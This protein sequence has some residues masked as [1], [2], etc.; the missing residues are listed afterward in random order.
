MV[1]AFP[2]RVYLPT[3]LLLDALGLGLQAL[4]PLGL[5]ALGLGLQ[6][7]LG[8]PQQPGPGELQWPRARKSEVCRLVGQFYGLF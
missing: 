5:R 2:L 8:P 7:P 3:V 6:A 1:G 4:G